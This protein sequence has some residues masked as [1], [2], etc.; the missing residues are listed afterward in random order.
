M[1]FLKWAFREDFCWLL[2]HLVQCEPDKLAGLGLT[3]Y[4]TRDWEKFLRIAENRPKLSSAMLW[5]QCSSPTRRWHSHT[6]GPFDLVSNIYL[7]YSMQH[8]CQ[9]AQLKSQGSTLYSYMCALLIKMLI[10]KKSG[11][12]FNDPSIYLH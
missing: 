1:F 9:A 7:I 10:R 8:E 2:A 5:Y 6:C 12:L 3:R 11:N 4:I